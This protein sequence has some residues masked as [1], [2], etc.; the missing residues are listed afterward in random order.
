[1][2]R[3]LVLI[4]LKEKKSITSRSFGENLPKKRQRI[5]NVVRSREKMA[6]DSH[7]LL[8]LLLLMLTL[9]LQH[10]AL[11]CGTQKEKNVG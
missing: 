4:F 3:A 6:N 5:F 11:N 9:L 2:E 7:H 1:M 10:C 8:L